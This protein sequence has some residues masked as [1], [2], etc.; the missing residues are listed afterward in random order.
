MTLH[1]FAIS[2]QSPQPAQDEFNRF[3]LA[4]RVV[5]IE[6]QFVADGANAYWALCVTLAVADASLP[7]ALKAPDSRAKSNAGGSRVDYKTVL[8]EQDFAL[9]A[10]LRNWR[11]SVA[12]AEGVPVYAVFTNEQLAEIV[13][14]R[15]DSLTVLGAIDGVGSSRVQRYG[16]TLLTHFQTALAENC[17]EGND[18]T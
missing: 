10:A 18:E 3:C 14:R 2:A 7:D 17:S 8:N 1:F 15:V 5:N 16:L 13:R 4:H 12:E 11:K 6:R 9:Y